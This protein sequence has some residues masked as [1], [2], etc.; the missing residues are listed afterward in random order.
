MQ[1]VIEHRVGAECEQDR[2]RVGEAG[3]LDHDPAKPLDLAGVAPVEEA[4]QGA[5]QVLSDGAA[6]APAGQFE[7]A[8]L[9]KV[10]KI[11]VDS[12]LTDFVD[13]DGGVGKSGRDEGAAQEGRFAAAEKAGQYGCRKGFR[14]SHSSRTLDRPVNPAPR[15]FHEVVVRTRSAVNTMR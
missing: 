6:K 9:D 13:D 2:R 5:S 8:A 14:L 15:S 7:H 12:D 11:V 4:A 10:E 3:R 1:T